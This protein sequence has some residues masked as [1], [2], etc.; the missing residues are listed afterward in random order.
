MPDAVPFYDLFANL[1][2]IFI[3][4]YFHFNSTSTIFIHFHFLLSLPILPAPKPRNHR[5]GKFFPSTIKLCLCCYCLIIKHYRELLLCHQ[6]H[7]SLLGTISR[8]SH[9]AFLILRLYSYISI[10]FICYSKTHSIYVYVLSKLIDI[11]RFK[12][13]EDNFFF[14]PPLSGM[15]F[16]IILGIKSFSA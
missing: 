9:S 8:Y 12:S 1:R 15:I 16:I 2:C 6:T 11:Q 14:L 3:S 13:E 4:T 7:S 5:H 10:K